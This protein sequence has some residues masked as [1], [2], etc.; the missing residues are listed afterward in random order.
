MMS[1]VLGVN[2]AVEHATIAAEIE[3]LI[4]GR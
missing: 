2:S 3:K 4:K 1:N